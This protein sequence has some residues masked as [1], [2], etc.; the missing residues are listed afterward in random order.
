[1]ILSMTGF[2]KAEGN[3]ENKKFVIE[4]RSV[5][6]RFAEIS[7]K[8][9][10]YMTSRDNEFKE[11]LRQKISRGKVNVNLNV[12]NGS[13]VQ[14][15]L[16][17]DAEVLKSYTKL[18]KTV[19][20]EI[21]SKEKIKL[22]HILHFTEIFTTEASGEISEEEFNFIKS[23]LNTAI[24]DLTAMKN[25]EGDYIKN[26]ILTRLNHID[27]ENEIIREISSSRIPQERIRLKEKIDSLIAD[28][29][30]IDENR[31]EM[32]L[33]L[34]SEKIDITEESIRLKSH[35]KFFSECVESNE[36]SGR[37]LNFLLQEMNREINTMASKSMDAEISQKVSLLKEEL[38]KIRE[39]IQNVE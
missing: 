6:S 10:K 27:S 12:E 35:L 23:I 28:K 34:L 11:I 37:R 18:L 19:R 22:E 17:I 21:G 5:N 31:L 7:F 24:D 26:D 32:E 38:E 20:K 30:K 15:Q 29:S 14:N 9:P 8:Y 25:K 16:T 1:M 3:F 39:Q 13:S 36:N 2:G 4:I 33:I